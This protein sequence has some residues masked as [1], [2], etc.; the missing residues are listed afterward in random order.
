MTLHL[1]ANL[2]FVVL[3]ICPVVVAASDVRGAQDHPKIKRY[4]GATILRYSSKDY[5]EYLMPLGPVSGRG[6]NAGFAK[7]LR[8]EG[9][10]TRITYVAPP[11]RS[12][13]EIIR[14][15]QSE[16][17]SAG[18][19]T[20]FEGAHQAIGEGDHDTAFAEARYHDLQLPSFSA[21]NF[22]MLASK[23]DRYLAARLARPEGSIYVAVYATAIAE[24]WGHYLSVDAADRKKV[25]QDGQVV[26]QVDI[27]EEKGM[28]SRMVTVS[29]G[30]MAT[31]LQ[32]TGSVALYGILF[33][34]NSTEI[35]AAS[36][37]TI[38]E[39]AKLMTSQPGL[40]LLV[41]GHTDNVG[42][43]DFNV[44][45]SRRRAASVV[46]MLTARYGVDERRLTPFG[47][48]FASPVASN[49]T[50]EGRGRNRRVEL[51]ENVSR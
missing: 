7:S 11:G 33:D 18:F 6:A 19:V 34:T 47:V 12:V 51:V 27:L 36:S 10:L 26:L 41:V 40:K 44:D 14:N 24:S 29:A 25:A 22:S 46:R 1:R 45:L 8:L 21:L 17:R 28:E 9:R 13:L 31:A 49:A 4:E 16:L 20:L 50:E 42:T 48:S 5:D 32:K 37:S 15:Y 43:F 35:K 2:V 3:L 23:D 38:E 39:I 30:E